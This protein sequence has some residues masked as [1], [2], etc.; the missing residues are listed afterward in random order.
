MTKEQLQAHV[1]TVLIEEP[2]LSGLSGQVDNKFEDAMKWLPLM[3]LA[4]IGGAVYLDGVRDDINEWIRK[5]IYGDHANNQFGILD[6]IDG[7]SLPVTLID[8]A[9]DWRTIGGEIDEG[10][11]E[12][13]SAD[14]T[15][16]WFGPAAG[17]YK[18][19]WEQQSL[20]FKAVSNICVVIA[21]ELEDLAQKILDFYADLAFGV[22]D[23]VAAI[24]T[25]LAGMASMRLFDG[26]DNI[27]DSVQ[28]AARL[29]MTAVTGTYN[30]TKD[31]TIAM[32]VM[33]QNFTQ[34]GLPQQTWPASKT[35]GYSDATV[36]DGNAAWSVVTDRYY[37]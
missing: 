27:A 5:A 16:R 24:V 10:H 19:V 36:R 22:A 34:V 1:D 31:V 26:A 25:D 15:A 4:G 17:A 18:T 9:N 30:L 23:L 28:A 13:N 32:N 3:G 21:T 29:I 6:I 7:I 2:K 35:S 12:R 20:G 33:N 11:T 14:L 8:V 37:R